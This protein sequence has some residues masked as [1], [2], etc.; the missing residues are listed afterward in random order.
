VKRIMICAAAGA[1]LAAG[2]VAAEAG[3]QQASAPGAQASA[4]KKLQ[5]RAV[6]S[7]G[8]RFSRKRL[9]APHG[10]VRITMLNPTSDK[11]PHAIAVEGHGIDKDG[12]VVQPGGRS[13]VTVR[14]K[15]GTYD[16]YCPVGQHRKAGMEGRLI[17]R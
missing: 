9:R 14:L 4:V 7:N 15:K 8:L 6:E 10:R 5:L 16:F 13:T 17:V 12:K 2:A 1:A 11:L 3:V